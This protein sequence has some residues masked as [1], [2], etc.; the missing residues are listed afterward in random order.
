MRYLL[1]DF[2]FFLVESAVL[3]MLAASVTSRLK[4][5][6]RAMILLSLDVLWGIATWQI[7][8]A[9]GLSGP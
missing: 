4:F 7:T 9:L 3:F 5:F 8:R 6:Q 2:F 1:V